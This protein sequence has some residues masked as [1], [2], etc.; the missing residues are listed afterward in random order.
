MLQ[1]GIPKKSPILLMILP[2]YG[3]ASS[4]ENSGAAAPRRV[5]TF[6]FCG[7][8]PP[9]CPLRSASDR[10]AALPRSAAM[11]QEAT[12]AAQ[13]TTVLV[14]HLVS[15][16]EQRGRDFKAE[17]LGGLEVDRKFVL[18]RRLHRQVGWFLTLE[19]AIDIA[20]GLPVGVD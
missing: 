10:S 11:C 20:G 5:R 16:G 6:N 19:D 14:D 18:G 7:S 17:C 2:M 1:I 15:A 9:Q 3:Q 13:Q 12:D 8:A 4:T